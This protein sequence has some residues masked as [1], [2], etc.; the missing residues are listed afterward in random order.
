MQAGWVPWDV[1]TPHLPG[2]ALEV[3]RHAGRGEID[4]QAVAAREA[5]A[6]GLVVDGD[7]GRQRVAQ[8]ALVRRLRSVKQACACQP[9]VPSPNRSD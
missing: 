9:A 7:R 3:G 1:R 4:A 5:Q 6:G 8:L 2:R